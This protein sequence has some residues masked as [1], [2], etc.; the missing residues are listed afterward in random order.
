MTY[1]GDIDYWNMKFKGRGDQPLSPDSAVVDN[2]DLLIPG[3]VLDIACGDG[4]NAL[5]LIDRG[6]E[7]TG[8][9]F[10]KCALERLVKFSIDRGYSVSTYQRD[11]T[12]D[13]AFEGIT[14]HDNIII[15]H[16]KLSQKLILM[17]PNLLN[18][19]GIMIVSGFSLN[20]PVDEK[21]RE[22]DLI[23]ADDFKV[24]E[25]K[26]QLIS[27]KE[28]NDSRGSFITLVYKRKET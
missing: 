2:R 24:I 26:M 5:Y 1:I 13:H 17:L 18:D 3:S 27:S 12:D 14:R 9:D 28:H 23:S 16:Y 6:Y 20:H 10:S 11:L 8:L 19:G 4:R 7:V 25:D 15:N 22:D 21:V